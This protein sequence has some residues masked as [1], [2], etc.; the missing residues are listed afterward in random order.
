MGKVGI[1]K[2]Q[3]QVIILGGIGRVCTLVFLPGDSHA[4]EPFGPQSVGSQRVR[5]NRVTE[6]AHKGKAR[7]S[8]FSF[9]EKTCKTGYWLRK[10]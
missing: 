3:A 2:N 6:H 7:E 10:L 1:G 5:Y 9:H 8:T 4:E